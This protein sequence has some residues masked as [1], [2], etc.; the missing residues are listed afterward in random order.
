MN[1]VLPST[2]GLSLGHADP[3]HRISV[4]NAG[5]QKSLTSLFTIP[6]AKTGSKDLLLTKLPAIVAGIAIL[7]LHPGIHIV[8]KLLQGSYRKVQ[9]WIALPPI[10]KNAPHCHSVTP[11][12]AN[13]HSTVSTFSH[14]DYPYKYLCR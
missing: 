2:R 10:I 7:G 13:V 9:L 1:C 8:L 3:A 4:P 6:R 5:Y 14:F 12:A 11:G